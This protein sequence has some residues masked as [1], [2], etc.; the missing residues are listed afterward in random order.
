[1]MSSIRRTGLVAHIA[2]AATL[3]GAGVTWAQPA[4]MEGIILARQ[5]NARDI[6]GAYRELNA[7]LKNPTPMKFLV[8]QYANQLSDLAND[9]IRW[10]PPGSGAESR[11]KTAAKA[12]IW[13]QAADFQ[14]A[15]AVF[16]DEAEKL[17][18]VA[19]SGD[20]AALA[21][22]VKA[23]A[24]TCKACHDKFKVP[25]EHDFQF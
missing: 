21:E 10:F 25:D 4:D 20:K 9:Q 2:V 22:Q 19:S 17:R 18:K 16:R 8:E 12:E 1:M 11:V 23:T 5:S 24:Q 6:G 3:I 14:A 15:N 7:E 13:T